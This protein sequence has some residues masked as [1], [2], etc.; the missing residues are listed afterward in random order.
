[1][2]TGV[3]TYLPATVPYVVATALLLST[4][5]PLVAL[6]TGAG[7]G[8]GRALTPL[9]RFLSRAGDDWDSSLATR[10]PVITVGGGV[11]VAAALVLL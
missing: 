1:L 9:T 11:V 7:F 2:G 8:L 4:P 3:R 5:D 6:A 10:L